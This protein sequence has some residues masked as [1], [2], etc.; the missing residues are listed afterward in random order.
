MVAVPLWAG[1]RVFGVMNIVRAG[2][3]TPLDEQDFATVLELGRRLGALLDRSR[4]FA[5]VTRALSHLR[6]LADAG[7]IL[8]STGDREEAIGK[9]VNL[10]VPAFADWCTVD[11]VDGNSIRRAA[12]RHT[13]RVADEV[14]DRLSEVTV[15]TGDMSDG[16]AHIVATGE[17]MFIPDAT[18]DESALS[19]LGASYFREMQ[20][21]GAASAIGVPLRS[22]D[23]IFGVLGLA[24]MPG[25]PAYDESDLALALELGRQ[26]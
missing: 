7:L 17:P 11:L 21:P 20:P 9:A 12:V 8:S 18:K 10:V 1:G 14:A 23:H 3:R 5:E 16:I 25:R 24:R 2:D 4:L 19:G 22:G 26:L 15:R 13:G 6:L